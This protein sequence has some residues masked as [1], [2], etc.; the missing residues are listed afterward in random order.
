MRPRIILTS[1]GKMAEETLRSAEM[2]AGPIDRIAVVSMTEADGLAGTAEK[3]S[4]VLQDADQT[5]EILVLADL[6]GGTP[7]NVAT[8]KMSEYPNLAVVTGLNLAMVIEAHF[9]LIE[10]AKALATYVEFIGTQAVEN[11]IMTA[12]AGDDEDDIEEIED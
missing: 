2:I 6:K 4:E 10:D 11:I 1:H 7:G 8:M 5:E 3:F 12:T 9:S